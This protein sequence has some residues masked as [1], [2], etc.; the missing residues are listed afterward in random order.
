MEIRQSHQFGG[1]SLGRSQQAEHQNVSLLALHLLKRNYPR[2]G[3][4]VQ[5]HPL[6]LAVPRVGYVVPGAK[7]PYVHSDCVQGVEDSESCAF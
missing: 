6:V 4:V 7:P 2:R 1:A 5:Q 3:S